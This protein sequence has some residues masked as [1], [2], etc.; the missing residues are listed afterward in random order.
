MIPE[1][2]STYTYTRESLGRLPAWIIG[3]DLVLEF[4]V[5]AATVAVGWSGYAQSLAAEFDLRL[6]ASLAGANT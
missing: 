3:W 4:A 6:P 2:G 1:A 5:A